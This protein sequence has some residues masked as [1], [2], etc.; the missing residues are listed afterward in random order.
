MKS[1]RPMM[2][3]GLVALLGGLIALINPTAAGVATTTLVGWAMLIIA[4]LQAWAAYRSETNAARLRAGAIC[5]VALL[6]AVLLLFG[7]FGN[8]W[9]MRL[10]VAILLLGSGAAKF[11]AGR[12][13]SGE[14][15]Q[16][17][18]FGAGGVSMLMGLVILLG[19][20]LQFGTLL[21]IELL[22]SGLAIVLLAMHRQ[23]RQDLIVDD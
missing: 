15:N 2:A 1:W 18:V 7:P 4:A 17:L 12:V 11:Y 9:L 21:G 19:L 5:V 3:A 6:M 23:S 14:Q 13:M 10:L 22:A 20:N 16:P 8:N